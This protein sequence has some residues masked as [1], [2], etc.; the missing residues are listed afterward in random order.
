M[1]LVPKIWNHIS[2]KHGFTLIEMIIVI[3]II[4][5]IFIAFRQYF[6]VQN[7]DILYGQSCIENIYGQVNNF[8]YGGLTS[9]TIFSGNNKNF[10]SLYT[11]TFDTTSQEISLGYEENG[12]A[13]NYETIS[14]LTGN[15]NN[16]C[17]TNGY[18]ILFSGDTYTLMVNKWLK[19]D[20]NLKFFFLTG[21]NSNFTGANTFRQC[22]PSNPGIDSTCK[23]IGRLETDTRSM[24]I[25]KQICLNINT[26]GVCDQRDN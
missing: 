19:E 4:S 15:S 12:T 2:K 14:L 20:Q 3:V 24:E 5:V 1:H 11:I 13:S 6:Q 10:P 17:T 23:N 9:K 18:Q 26:G 25:K 8:L 7:R 22:P 21:N 16:L